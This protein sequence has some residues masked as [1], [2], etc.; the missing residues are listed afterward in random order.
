[1]QSYKV[2]IVG[3]MP[4]L[5]HNDNIEWA[6]ELAAW[7]K[8]PE[9][10]KSTTPGD[11]R[12]PGFT[13]MGSLYTHNGLL[14]MPS[15][16]IDACLMKAA[17]QI[18]RRGMKTYRS[19]IVS[20]LITDET[21]FPILLKGKPFKIESISSLAKERD[22]GEHKRRV[23]ELDVNSGDGEGMR[24]FSL[25]V[26]RG[27]IG[28]GKHVR[29]RPMLRNWSV[30]MVVN[31]TDHSLGSVLPDVLKIAGRSIGLGD[32]RPGGKTPGRYGTFEGTVR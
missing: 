8:N 9:I 7:R 11:D 16:N 30:E 20:N 19:D 27:A 5:L 23:A 10:K 17:G 21:Q 18:T 28:T 4:L 29:V 24:T 26:V 3:K 12:T 14:V 15:K 1:M 31:V 22:F 13:W 25:H 32:W 2:S 6:D